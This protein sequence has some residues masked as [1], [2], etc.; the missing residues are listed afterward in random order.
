MK[1]RDPK[2]LNKYNLDREALNH[3]VIK[4]RS[5]LCPPLFWRN[6]IVSAW[7]ISED[8][9]RNSDDWE[10]CTYNEYWLGVYDEDAPKHAGEIVVNFSSSGGM[11]WYKFEKF[12]DYQEIDNE[13]DLR[14]QE[15]FLNKIN[16]LIDEGILEVEK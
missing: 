2:V 6:D 5:K 7:C 14:I 16:M 11:C 4:D 3:L 13:M 9:A 1:K 15:M 12:Y 8:T 10:F